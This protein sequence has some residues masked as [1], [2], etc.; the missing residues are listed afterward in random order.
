MGSGL[1]EG[2]TTGFV[3][4]CR[5]PL[6]QQSG[7]DHAN[8]Y[9]GKI[10]EP[11]MIMPVEAFVGRERELAKL[12]T[13]LD[14]AIA[15]RG[16]LVMLS[17][18]P[19]I[20]KTRLARELTDQATPCTAHIVWGRCHEE[21]GAPP[22][23]PW[24]RILRAI[25]VELEPAV[26]LGEL[27]AGAPDIAELVPEL[28]EQLPDL[29]PATPLRDPAEARFR[30]FG[31]LTR[32]LINLSRRQLLVLVLDDLHWADVPSLRLLEFL[33]PEI[34][35]SGLLVIGTYRETELSRRH[36]LSDTLGALARV[37]HVERVHLSG[38]SAEEARRFIATSAGVIPPVWLTRAIHDQTEGNPLFLREMVRFLQQEGHFQA[39]ALELATAPS[40]IRIPEGV[41]EV[42]GRRL[43]LLSPACNEVLSLAAVVGRD[44]GLD[45]LVRAGRDRSEDA[46]L[47]A[48]DEALE[49]RVAEETTP[50]QYQFSHALLRMTLYDE[51]RT[52]ERRRLHRRVGQ[53]IEVLHRRDQDLVLPDL[54]RH[55][56]AAG[57]DD[58]AEQTID[59]T[60]RAGQRADTLLAFEDAIAFFQT[61]LDLQEHA[62]IDAPRQRWLL[63]LQ[64]GEAQRKANDFT[65]ALATLRNAAEIARR[66]QLPVEFARAAAFRAGRVHFRARFRER[67][68]GWPE[69]HLLIR[70]KELAA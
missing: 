17:G 26:L 20:G 61:A 47:E 53:A 21:A 50:G 41:R 33:A 3:K 63:L 54:A 60:T 7:N 67:K 19:G 65:N 25:V 24:V 55:F 52:G 8:A 6:H 64:L 68:I 34:A 14:A 11:L 27:G 13:A 59:Y 46:V 57:F 35:D 10:T 58:D 31:S 18:E 70:P 45:V 9:P 12:R 5:L 23:W 66:H 56:H 29:E 40:A 36:R 43:N 2:Y 44:F 42:I 30:L 1:T 51:L 62:N 49:A 28:R 48:L 4:L 38:L 32:F 16:R 39:G 69:S 22:Y 15:G 37:P